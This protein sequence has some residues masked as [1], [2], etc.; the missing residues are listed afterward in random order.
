MA[1]PAKRSYAQAFKGQG[2]IPIAR[3]IYA[4]V[5]GGP[6]PPLPI[7]TDQ[8]RQSTGTTKERYG[9]QPAQNGGS[10]DH[11]QDVPTK[12]TG[13]GWDSPPPKVAPPSARSKQPLGYRVSCWLIDNP[14]VEEAGPE[15]L[16]PDQTTPQRPQQLRGERGRGARKLCGC[17]RVH[18]RQQEGAQRP[19]YFSG[20]KEDGPFSQWLPG[21]EQEITGFGMVGRQP[22]TH[23]I[24]HL[25]GA[26]S[27]LGTQGGLSATYDQI[28]ARL[29]AAYG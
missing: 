7:A 25:R 14:R 15:E 9:S 23:L 24:N 17:S 29:I 5:L 18:H 13:E 19:K 8:G 2:N 27:N 1:P 22:I 12:I 21:L 11:A 3:R 28:V 20:K 6:R 4:P 10:F 26:A 16:E